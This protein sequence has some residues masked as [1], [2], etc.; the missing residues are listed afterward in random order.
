MSI[1]YRATE[2]EVHGVQT[3]HIG[4]IGVFFY[5]RILHINNEKCIIIILL[6]N[7]KVHENVYDPSKKYSRKI[8]NSQF[9]VPVLYLYVYDKE[10]LSSK[11]YSE[12]I[13]EYY[14]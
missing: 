8:L 14:F 5:N 13:Y 10:I 7:F 6:Y 9:N 12:V 1:L 2:G 11:L 4:H 3:F